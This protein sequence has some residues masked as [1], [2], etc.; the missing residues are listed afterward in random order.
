[1]SNF[2]YNTAVAKMM[3]ALNNL[4]DIK[5][6]ISKSDIKSLVKLIAP[7]APYMAEELWSGLLNGSKESVSV[8]LESWPEVDEQY[9]VEEEINLPVAINGKVRS[10]ILID[11]TQISDKE[12]ILGKVKADEKIIKWI[13]ESKIVKEIYVPGKMVNLVVQ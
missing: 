1:L 12:F 5:C 2:K 7:L 9:L 11:Q 13:G 8:H 10:Q 3:E 6:Q 4:S